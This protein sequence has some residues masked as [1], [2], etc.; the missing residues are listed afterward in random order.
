[1]TKIPAFIAEVRAAAV[2][3]IRTGAVRFAFILAFWLPAGSPATA[4]KWPGTGANPGAAIAAKVI[5]EQCPGVLSASEISELD[6][7]LSKWE[8]DVKQLDEAE[9]SRDSTYQPFPI[10]KFPKLRKA[11][12][13]EYTK[14]YR[15]PKNCNAD[16]V[17]E[18]RDTL[19]RV[20]QEMASGKP[21]YSARPNRDGTPEAGAK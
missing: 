1:M 17:E 21:L 11:L 16:A 13:D 5:G 6:A 19:Q 14:K 9:K 20:K 3:F 18:A 10:E 7:Y 8:A 4:Y 15:D 12:G 2:W